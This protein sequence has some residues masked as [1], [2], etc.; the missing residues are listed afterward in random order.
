MVTGLVTASVLV[1]FLLSLVLI[2]SRSRLDSSGGYRLTLFASG[3]TT[4]SLVALLSHADSH[5]VL[6]L[7]WKPGAGAMGLAPGATSLLAALATSATLFVVLLSQASAEEGFRPVSGATWLLALSTANVAFLAD[8]FLARYVALEVVAL[9]VALVLLADRHG[10]VRFRPAW[11]TYLLLRVGDAGLLAAIFVLLQS[12]GTLNIKK[13]LEAGAA[14]EGQP[15]TYAAAGFLLAVWVKLGGWPFHVWSQP[16]RR[17]GLTSQA[18]LYSTVMANLG[19]YLLYRVTPLLHLSL[20]LETATIWVGSAGAAVAAVI[21]LAQ[22]D[23]RAALVYF[24]AVQA[25]LAV[26]AAGA[27]VKSAVWL[28]VVAMTLPRAL[29]YLAAD[30]A[31]HGTQRWHRRAASWLFGLGGIFLLAFGLLLTWWARA[32]HAPLDALLVAEVGVAVS[33]VWLSRATRK[34]SAGAPRAAQLRADRWRILV[35]GLTGLGVLVGA[36]GFRSLVS[37]LTVYADLSPITVPPLS[38]LGRHALALPAVWA[39]ILAGWGLWQLQRRTGRQPLTLPGVSLQP[40]ELEEVLARTAQVLHG[41]IEVG[42]LERTLTAAVGAV[43]GGSRL[44][45]RVVEQQ[46]LEGLQTTIARVLF[47]GSRLWHDAFEEQGVDRLMRGAARAVQVL[48]QGLYH[49]IEGEGFDD[50]LRKVVNAFMRR[51]RAT[52]RL[53]EQEGTAELER[54][55]AQVLMGGAR[56]AYRS[57]E[58]E[59]SEGIL[60][61]VVGAALGWGHGLQRWQTGR[62]RYNLMWVL[63]SLVIVIVVLVIIAW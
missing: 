10:P 42:L 39:V 33:V 15:L 23:L 24:S 32:A 50:W 2:L 22:D 44:I 14:M 53:V 36:V 51:I 46:G 7:H 47:V 3:L 38:M 21:L 41:I 29:L 40:Y 9:C 18:W 25:G 52:Y 28:S 17:V 6:S 61:P 34:L 45:Y 31:Q 59:G 27:G 11:T 12:S 49:I 30:F 58:E 26:L 13:A 20:P 16:G 55:A 54:R 60:K 19:L 1:P 62:L 5:A 63:G 57:V 37:W 43:T 35:A 4:S 56:R 48:A 8:H